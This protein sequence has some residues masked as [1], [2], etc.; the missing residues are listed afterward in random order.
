MKKLS[1]SLYSIFIVGFIARVLLLIL[2]PQKATILAPDEAAYAGLTYWVSHGLDIRDFPVHGHGLYER[3]RTYILFSV[4]FYRMGFDEYTATRLT[5]LTFSIS[6]SFILLRLFLNQLV[7]TP[8]LKPLLSFSL[9]FVF[10]FLNLLPSYILWSVLAIRETT[11][12]FF[13]FLSSLIFSK[14]LLKEPKFKL[15]TLLLFV[16]VALAFGVRAQSVW[17]LLA[18]FLV[19]SWFVRDTFFR[20]LGLTTLILVSFTI[21][22]F[23]T[24][25]TSYL[26]K[27]DLTVTTPA[28]TSVTA[29]KESKTKILLSESF[30]APLISIFQLDDRRANNQQF[31]ASAVT[32]PVCNNDG[33][34]QFFCEVSLM[35]YQLISFLFRPLPLIDTGSPLLIVASIENLFWVALYVLVLILVKE[36][37]KTVGVKLFLSDQ[38][39]RLH[40]IFLVTF[41]VSA[42]M[43]FGNLGTGFRHKTT[44]LW[45]IS[46][47]VLRLVQIA[48]KD[49][50][51]KMSLGKLAWKQ[52]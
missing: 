25:N 47:L 24:S 31:A 14:I 1:A 8:A 40:A 13:I 10:A 33:V 35:G 6:L 45:C 52:N 43:Y 49:S 37:Y 15:N 36:A 29:P 46:L 34:R 26:Y 48:G 21:G 42:S 3:T 18:T 16:F 17:I 22:T 28:P 4:L 30:Q 44:L 50:M 51:S 2:L 39:V 12:H 20:K 38:L 7:R 32:P 5:S 41:S 9:V 27:S 23:W 11:S 19:C